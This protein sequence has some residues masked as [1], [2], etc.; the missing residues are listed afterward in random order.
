MAAF[1][2]GS[3]S[4][5][6]IVRWC[7]AVSGRTH[8]DPHEERVQLRVFAEQDLGAAHALSV[9]VGWP[10]RLRDWQAI[11]GIGSG[12]VACDALQRVVG[13]AMLWP[14]GARFGAV[15]MVIVAPGLQRQGTG[16]RLLRAVVDAAMD[17]TL[18]LTATGSGLLLYQSEGFRAIATINQHQGIARRRGG[19]AVVANVRASVARD[20]AKIVEIDRA[21]TG[22]DRA[23]ALHAL[24]GGASGTVSI[25]DGVMTGFAFSRPFGRGY[26]VGPLVAPDDTTAIALMMPHIDNNA[27]RMLR[28]DTPHREGRFSR[29]LEQSGLFLADQAVTMVRGS[30]LAKSNRSWIYALVNQALG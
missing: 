8:A 10:H 11:F 2:R 16:R 23:G 24:I 15:G 27:G 21:A 13:T 28:V 17:R 25:H 18:Q 6:D 5:R 19:A 7:L 29:F 14:L 1:A 30:G 9:A 20:W 26:V 3:P 22:V 12:F 4:R